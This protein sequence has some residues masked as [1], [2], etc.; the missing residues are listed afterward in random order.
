M[1]IFR[2]FQKK[3]VKNKTVR[4]GA[5]MCPPGQ[6]LYYF[7]STRSSGQNA[8]LFNTFRQILGP[9]RYQKC[10]SRHPNL[11]LKMEIFPNIAIFG[12][13]CH[14]GAKLEFLVT[15]FNTL[16]DPRFVEKY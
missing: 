1:A 13:N 10:Y 3:I 9:L 7:G 14:F 11:G 6:R 16:V 4:K 2:V 8:S 5:H 12:K 15:Y